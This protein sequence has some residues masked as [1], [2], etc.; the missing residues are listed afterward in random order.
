MVIKISEYKNSGT[1]RVLDLSLQA[2]P[3]FAGK[4][5]QVELKIEVTISKN[6][7]HSRV[8]QGHH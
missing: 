2:V 7:V 1:I 5:N 6:K 3:E 4:L 8:L